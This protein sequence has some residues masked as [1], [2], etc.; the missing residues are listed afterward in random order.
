[1][2]WAET[3]VIRLV[4][5]LFLRA[6][7][8]HKDQEIPQAIIR[9]R[10]RAALCSTYRPEVRLGKDELGIEHR[11]GPVRPHLI[12]VRCRDVVVPINEPQ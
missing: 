5:H 1:M 4:Q 8:G 10:K 7:L 9:H 6:H 3:F 11:R 12:Y 2:G